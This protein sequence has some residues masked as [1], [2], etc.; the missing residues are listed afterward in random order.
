MFLQ[1]TAICLLA[2]CLVNFCCD[3]DTDL[4]KGMGLQVVK[5]SEVSIPI[6]LLFSQQL[7]EGENEIISRFS[8]QE[9]ILLPSG[10]YPVTVNH[11]MRSPV[12]L[13]TGQEPIKHTD[14]VVSQRRLII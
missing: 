10:C 2:G 4:E 12:A 6:S 9:I 3:V 1:T 11:F 13:K 5:I 14:L 8:H 7:N